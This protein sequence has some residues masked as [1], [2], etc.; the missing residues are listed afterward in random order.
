MLTRRKPLKRKPR[1]KQPGDDPAYLAWIRTL[2]CWICFKSSY[3]SGE[4]WAGLHLIQA[5]QFVC[6]Q[7]FRTEAAH[8]GR[9]AYGRKCPD[10]QAMPLCGDAHHREGFH[11]HHRMGRYFWAHHNL[12][13]DSIIRQL[14]ERYDQLHV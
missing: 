3:E 12:D 9:R 6:L 7:A 10:R 5:G 13:R 2:P 14:N 4:I 11:S 8:V 1:K